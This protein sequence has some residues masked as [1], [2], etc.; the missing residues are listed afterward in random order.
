MMTKRR[1]WLSISPAT[2]DASAV[3]LRN[4][5]NSIVLAHRIALAVDSKSRRAGLLG[6]EGLDE[7]NAL[8]LAP[9]SAIHT[10]FMQFAIDICFVGRDGCVVRAH[11]DVRPW[12]I[13]GAYGAFA[14]IELPSGVLAR[15]GTRR[16]DALELVS[17]PASS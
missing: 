6:R 15:S 2:R 13:A 7:G 5:R 3:L 11:Q 10:W 1:D 17:I 16:G 9:T 8:I 12:R 4:A 14:A